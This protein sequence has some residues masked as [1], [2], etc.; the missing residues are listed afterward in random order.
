MVSIKQYYG[1]SSST[2][3]YIPSS[4]RNVTITGGKLFYGAFYNCSN[5]VN[6][7]LGDDVDYIGDYA[8]YNCSNLVNITLG[9]DVEYIGDCAFY[10]C[11]KP[12][13]TLG[14][15]VE[16][17]GDYAFYNVNNTKSLNISD[18]VTYIGKHAF[19][20]MNSLETLYMAGATPA[21]LGGATAL[22]KFTT[23]YVP[24][25][26]ARV[27]Y[28]KDALWADHQA[29]I[30]AL[31]TKTDYDVNVTAL[32]DKSALHM[33]IGE[34][35]LINV[36]KLKVSGTINSYD[37][38][39]MRNKMV[40]LKDLD[41][42]EAT[43]VSNSYEYFSNNGTG[44]SSVDNKLT[45]YAL[46][47]N[48]FAVKLPKSLTSIE[49]NALGELTHVDEIE[50]P[51]NV[52][53]LGSYAAYD[54]KY[55]KAF[56]F[57]QDSKLQ[58]IGSYAF[59]YCSSLKEL[60]IP[61]SVTAINDYA[62]DYCSSLS[63]LVFEDGEEDM[64]LNKN[65]S[66]SPLAEVYIGR[67]IINNYGSY[68]TSPFSSK[69]LLKKV[70]I[71]N[72][73]TSIPSYLFY[74]SAC[75]ELVVAPSLKTIGTSAFYKNL[76]TDINIED[77]NAW[78]NIEGLQ[79]LMS[80]TTAKNF[81]LNGEK[82]ETLDLTG[83]ETMQPYAF[84]HA[85]I[86]GLNIPTNS[87]LESIP[88]YAFA[89]TQ[90]NK[91]QMPVSI[92][93]VGAYAFS[94]C[95]NLAEV[96]LPS[97]IR[98]IG[99]H[100]FDGCNVL[101]DVYTYTIEPQAI[102][103]YTFSTYQAATLHCPKV[104]YYTYFYDTQWSQFLKLVD[105]DEPY[106]YIFIDKDVT[107]ND[108]TG[109]IDG[110][111]DADINAGGGLIVEGSH[112]QVLDEIHIKFDGSINVGASLVGKVHAN[113]IFLDLMV[114]ADKWYYFSFPFNVDLATIQ[115]TG[116]YVFRY[117]DG[118]ARANGNTGWKNVEAGTTHLT[119]GDGYIFS[120]NT[121]GLLTIVIDKKTIEEFDLTVDKL[122]GL[123]SYTATTSGETSD[124]NKSWN[125][126]GN[127]YLCYYSMNEMDY[128]APVIVWNGTSYEAFR[129]GDDDYTFYPFQAFFVQKPENVEGV[130][131]D[132][133]N[134]TTYLQSQ[135][136]STKAASRA[137]KARALNSNRKLINLTLTDGTTTDKTRVVFNDEQSL[138][139][140]MACDASKFETSGVA[141]LYSIGADGVKYSINERP[142]A[143][144]EVKL[145]YVAVK[146]G[147]VTISVARMDAHVL[148]KDAK[149][150]T[151][152]DFSDG[153]YTFTSEAGAF[154][155]RF[156]LVL[157]DEATPIE[158]VEAES[159]KLQSTKIYDLNGRRI[160]EGQ[161]G[162]NI[163]DGKKVINQ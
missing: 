77:V 21:T 43:I 116:G 34:N 107:I 114:D 134:Q 104:S 101:Y 129:P 85:T 124:A 146:K 69:S 29:Q 159:E 151:I 156:T 91:L 76:T 19:D 110:T 132:K 40:N 140:E 64:S 113:K 70:T 112:D 138:S 42:S 6:I 155:G 5:L 149:T 158:K 150:G 63:K 144:G 135:D 58:T 163:K 94:N 81:Y 22:S 46:Q 65:S 162:V 100:A 32:P 121:A 9:D 60:S 39:L 30:I 137:R 127:P 82:I 125:F 38:M 1:S 108:N 87:T 54:L 73:V 86:T 59:Y 145:G 84:D 18:K 128:N 72:G 25:E 66:S 15:D 36:L 51:A 95:A 71:G 55:L 10:N 12:N 50:V 57:A 11:Y 118:Q 33:T 27:E 61:G 143:N 130:G 35:N 160:G 62:L 45:R 44:Y 20:N 56:T 47:P 115:K 157:D 142:I 17:I 105:F 139:Y 133:D 37:L 123:N 152:F 53:T 28:I 99:N 109:T 13:I 88:D 148:L 98:S 161:R 153:D 4:L 7:T 67:N 41:L 97:S 52:V 8:F 154:E 96:K 24:N 78:S 49:D 23:I 31:G 111:P 79:T 48:L 122:T 126:I 90:I 80:T 147:E 83:V 14:D 26:A 119:A 89:N 103:Q 102:D 93:S 136:E 68:T 117:Y 131:F 141:Q 120:T 16:Y 106:D 92:T 3:Y 2:T 75:N 74:N